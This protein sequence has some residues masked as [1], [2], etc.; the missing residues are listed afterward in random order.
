MVGMTWHPKTLKAL[1][2]RRRLTQAA[3][4]ERAGIHQVTVARLESGARRPGLRT[5]EKLARALGVDLGALLK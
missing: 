5:L 3:L 4:A 2:A 1:R